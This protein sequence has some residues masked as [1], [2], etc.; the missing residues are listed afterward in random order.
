MIKSVLS[1]DLSSEG[2]RE[3]ELVKE[4]TSSVCEE[5][6]N[7][8]AVLLDKGHMDEELINKGYIDKRHVENTTTFQTYG[9]NTFAKLWVDEGVAAVDIKH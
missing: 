8:A 1:E 6:I 4:E 9:Y 5:L 2:I 7:I 3:P